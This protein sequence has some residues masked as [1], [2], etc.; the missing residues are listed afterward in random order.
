MIL[1]LITLAISLP[2]LLFVLFILL[3]GKKQYGDG[4]SGLNKNEFPLKDMMYMGA[5]LGYDILKEKHLEISPRQVE[6]ARQIYGQM[7][8][9]REVE[10]K[11]RL[12]YIHK[13]TMLALLVGAAS[14]IGVFASV[15]GLMEGEPPKPQEVSQIE[16]PNFLDGDKEI[17]YQVLAENENPADAENKQSDVTVKVVIPRQDP[18][19]EELQQALEIAKQNL[20]TRGLGKNSDWDNIR[21]SMNFYEYDR[22]TGIRLQWMLEE[23][24]AFFYDGELR[25][26]KRPEEGKTE[27][28]T[29]SLFY[30]EQK[31]D[32]VTKKMTILPMEYTD[33]ELRV[34]AVKEASSE[35]N[36]KN[37][38]VEKDKVVLPAADE[39][40]KVQMQWYEYLEAAEGSTGTAALQYFLFLMVIAVMIYFLYDREL[41]RQVD[42]RKAEIE[43]EFP[44][45][46]DKFV[47]LLNCGNSV[48]GALN[49]SIQSVLA[50]S[51]EKENHPLYQEL[52]ILRQEI[53]QGIA[54]VD[55]FENFGRRVRISSIMKFSSLIGQAIRKGDKEIS[56]SLSGLVKEAW[57]KKKQIAKEK[58]AQ[59]STKMIFP[60]A[61]MLIAIV[62]MI[63]APAIF[64]M[65][66]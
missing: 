51:P 46:I 21:S 53:Q 41:Q 15:Q 4:Y 31:L 47:L 62:M 19:E 63:M 58:G 34:N 16:R 36:Q 60:L 24:S 1:N 57:E 8:G 20:E 7:S 65:S 39:E 12:F 17:T 56:N 11:V 28:V 23:G 40:K 48:F 49:Q 66:F 27:Y 45:F 54:D 18:T 64:Q 9:R 35:I 10:N 22:E 13:L 42:E 14:M 61:I 43:S 59:A 32:E 26:G 33:E 6:R 55:A 30:E 52:M 2:I 38:F 5:F 29:V 37:Q 44:I 3:R 50:N 25:G